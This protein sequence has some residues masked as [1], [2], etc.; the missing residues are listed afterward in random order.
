MNIKKATVFCGASRTCKNEYLEQASKLGE[1]LAQ[2]GI[3][4]IYGGGNIGL[5]GHLADGALSND[6]KVTGIIP[7]FLQDLELG[8]KGITELRQVENLHKREEIMMTEPDCIIALPGG[9]GTFS[10]LLQ[11]I[12]WKRLWQ[13]KSPIIIVNI[14]DYFKPLIDMLNRPIDENFLKEEF[15][16][17]WTVVNNVDEAMKSLEKQKLS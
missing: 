9:I 16:N 11:S 5:M 4:I 7:N 8:H 6:G 17:L 3:E 13:I 15:A 2:K 12:T 1:L 10:E 14:N